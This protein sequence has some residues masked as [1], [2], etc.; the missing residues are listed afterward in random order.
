MRIGDMMGNPYPLEKGIKRLIFT[1][2]IGLS[3]KNFVVKLTFHKTLKIMKALED[4]RF[5]MQKTD[6]CEFTV[7]INKTNIIVVSSNRD[8]RRARTSKK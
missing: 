8:G 1:S 4:L 2:P 7:V 5:M 3:S 6:P